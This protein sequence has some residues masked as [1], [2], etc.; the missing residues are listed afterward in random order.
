MKRRAPGAWISL[1]TSYYAAPVCQPMSLLDDADLL[2]GSARGIA[3]SLSELLS[4]DGESHPV[5]LADAL[6]GVALLVEMGQS[7]AQEANRRIQKLRRSL[8]VVE[9]EKDVEA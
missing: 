6:W 3:Q 8:R 2:L 9:K 5:G 1:N 4:Q 7:S